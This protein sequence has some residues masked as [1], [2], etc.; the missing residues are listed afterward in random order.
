ME[1]HKVQENEEETE[2]R[3]DDEV[4]EV[5]TWRGIKGS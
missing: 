3:E 4:K 1:E 5:Y 2:D